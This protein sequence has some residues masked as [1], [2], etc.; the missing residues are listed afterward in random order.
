MIRRPPRSTLFPYTTLFRSCRT[1]IK[2]DEQWL[3]LIEI[4]QLASED[5]ENLRQ[6]N[7]PINLSTQAYDGVLNS[8]ISLIRGRKLLEEK[9]GR[10]RMDPQ[11]AD[12]VNYYANS[13]VF[14]K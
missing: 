6:Q 7:A 8:A 1:L 14:W 5:I 9:D 3:T 11:S 10:L 13:I 12:I 4:K 2:H